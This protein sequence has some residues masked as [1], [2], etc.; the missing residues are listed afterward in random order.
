MSLP[1]VAAADL[2]S[3]AVGHQAKLEGFMAASVM[4][5]IMGMLAV[6]LWST[7]RALGAG[8]RWAAV[9]AVGAVFGT[10]A[11]PYGKDFFSE[12][13][14]ALAIAVSFREILAGRALTAGLALALAITTRPE[15]GVLLAVLPLIVWSFQGSRRAIVYGAAAAMG[16]LVDA[17]YDQYRFGSVFNS[18]YKGEGFTTPFFHGAA[19]L[20]YSPTKGVLLFAPISV[21]LIFGAVRLW[22][23]NDKLFVLLAA[24]NFVVFFVLSALWHSWQGGW[25]WGPRLILPGVLVALPLLAGAS[26]GEK[27]AGLGLFVIGFAVSASTILVPV[28]AQQLDNPPPTIGPAIIRQ[29]ALTPSVISYSVHHLHVPHTTAGAHRRY[30]SLWQVNFGREFGTGGLL[31]GAL[32]SIALLAALAAVLS[33]G[34]WPLFTVT[35]PPPP[36]RVLSP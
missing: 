5:L 23:A 17:A 26:Q 15:A 21:L 14:T 32:G 22:R 19:G 18:G 20:I 11:L 35:R 2:L 30:V 13:L 16:G 6:T 12:P 9:V 28:Q 27:R 29:Y 33:R 36:V 8:R 7:A 24:A 25:S 1:F 34:M 31:L 10:Y 3:V 4:P